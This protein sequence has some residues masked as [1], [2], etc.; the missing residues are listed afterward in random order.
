MSQLIWRFGRFTSPVVFS[1]LPCAFR[2][3]LFWW[4]FFFQ[5]T[6]GSVC[7]VFVPFH[8]C[9]LF[10]A[11]YFFA[12]S[13]PVPVLSY[14]YINIYTYI[15]VFIK[16][17]YAHTQEPVAHFILTCLSPHGL[18]LLVARFAHWKHGASTTPPA[19]W[20]KCLLLIEGE[21]LKAFHPSAIYIRL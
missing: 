4:R 17:P 21:A 9:V 19:I 13:S 5:C 12:F 16:S 10:F 3:F 1:V 8:F 18:P 2:F 6:F 20:N 15:L 14:D 7:F 11:V